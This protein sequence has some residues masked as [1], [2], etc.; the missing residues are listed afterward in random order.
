MRTCA[1]NIP[2]Y[3]WYLFSCFIMMTFGDYSSWLFS[4]EL[5][6]IGGAFFLYIG[7]RMIVWSSCN[8]SLIITFCSFPNL[9]SL[10]HT[11]FSNN[12]SGTIMHRKEKKYTLVAWVD[13]EV[14]VTVYIFVWEAN[15]WKDFLQVG[16]PSNWVV[17]IPEEYKKICV[18]YS[19]CVI[20][21]YECT[22]SILG[23]R[24]PFNDFKV[25][26]LNHLMI[27]PSQFDLVSW[28]F[29]KVFLYWC[30]YRGGKPSL[31]LFF[32]LLKVQCSA[33]NHTQ[34]QGLITLMQV[35]RYFEVYLDGM[36]HFED[37]L[38]FVTPHN[39]E[40]HTKDCAI[41]IEPKAMYNF[42]S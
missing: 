30:V 21:F 10:K 29:I 6:T 13:P 9:N 8:V 33:V 31:S 32:Y 27:S 34:G 4:E 16:P 20:P 38:S 41:E 25:Y 17:M 19:V 40:A 35:T 22:F 5:W 28:D 7:W 36:K 1:L 2:P 3:S 26:I 14:S 11:I 23:L 12:G 42:I 18:K 37:D 39:E 15:L 24:F